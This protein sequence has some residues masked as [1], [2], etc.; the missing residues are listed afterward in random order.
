MSGFLITALLL[1]ERGRS[2]S[3][4]LPRFYRRRALRLLPALFV[5]VALVGAFS[6]ATGSDFAPPRDVAA[7]LLYYANWQEAFGHRLVGLEHT[8]SLAV[9]EQFYL[10]WPLLMIL[11]ARLGRRGVLVTALGGALL[12]LVWRIVLFAEGAS[13]QRLY[14][15]ADTRADCIL[16]GCALAV[17]MSGRLDRVARPRLANATVAVTAAVAAALVAAG[18]LGRWA[19]LPTV[20]ASGTALVIWHVARDDYRGWFAHPLMRLVGQ[21]SYA[22]YLWGFPIGGLVH[23]A[24]PELSPVVTLPLILG[25]T[26]CAAALSWRYVE[27]PFLR[28]KARGRPP[29]GSTGLDQTH[30]V[31]PLV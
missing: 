30:A 3:L 23:V 26:A 4:D 7:A 27:S 9:E 1:K 12:S 6:W 15:G 31:V 5:M 24:V 18:G 28:L 29:H 13:T 20:I 14:F 17:V 16:I 21:R 2:G 11:A 19:L 10:A 8:W 25:L 22:L